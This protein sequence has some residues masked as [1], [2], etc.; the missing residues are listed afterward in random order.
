MSN[1]TNRVNHFIY[2]MI[3]LIPSKTCFH[4]EPRL[5]LVSMEINDQWWP[6]IHSFI[7]LFIHHKNSFYFVQLVIRVY[8][9]IYKTQN[10]RSKVDRI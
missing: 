9:L 7:F 10:V 5:Q 1:F 6:N 4:W 3:L 8:N 2:S